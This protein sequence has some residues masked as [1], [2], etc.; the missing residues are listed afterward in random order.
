MPSS[1]TNG[2]APALAQ[3][4]WPLALL[5]IVSGS[6]SWGLLVLL[7]DVLDINPTLLPHDEMPFVGPLSTVP[8][9]VFGLCF[10]GALLWRRSLGLGRFLAYVLASIVGYLAAYHAA[11]FSALGVASW[12][13]DR[14]MG[15]MAW[16]V[17]GLLGGLA[18]SFVLGLISRFLL[19]TSWAEVLGM[20]LIVGTVAGVLLLLMAFDSEGHGAPISLLVLFAAW[21]ALYA[22]SLAPLLQRIGIAR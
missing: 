12:S 22:S 13:D 17:G 21:Q 14:N 4:S 3:F 18:G 9:L 15:L 10:G 7:L 2:V 1:S 16:T 19:R 8:G 20:P 11:F 6:V 5:G